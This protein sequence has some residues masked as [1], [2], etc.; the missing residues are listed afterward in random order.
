MLAVSALGIAGIATSAQAGGVTPTI[1][2]TPTN[3]APGGAMVLTI[4]GA[5]CVPGGGG[6]SDEVFRLQIYSYALDMY[7]FPPSYLLGSDFSGGS[8][9]TTAYTA[10]VAAGKYDLVVSGRGA[11]SGVS[12]SLVFTVGVAGPTTTVAPTTTAAPTTSVATV[13]P[14]TSVPT[15]PATGGGFDLA[16]VAALLCLAGGGVIMLTRR[17][18]LG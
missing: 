10:P 2:V 6:G 1:S 5:S 8:L 9:T 17:Q 16:G 18:R 7:P 11:C 12:T 14:T 13:G 3:V 15:L 4:S